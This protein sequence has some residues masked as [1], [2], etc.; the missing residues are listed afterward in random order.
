MN[1]D[2]HIFKLFDNYVSEQTNYT[3][4]Y[5]IFYN[6]K[7]DKNIFIQDLSK[8]LNIETATLLP[9]G[10]SMLKSNFDTLKNIYI[11][12]MLIIITSIFISSLFQTLKNSNK[13]GIY[14]LLGISNA[15][16]IKNN[17]LTENKSALIITMITYILLNLLIPNNNIVFCLLSFAI[18]LI[19]II[20]KLIITIIST[21]IICKKINLINLI[22]KEK[23]TEQ[24]IQFK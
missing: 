3:G 9:S 22:K 18:I 6:D 5:K 10:Y 1:N 16:I 14:R 15:K 19:I 7:N 23:I 12:S 2:Y 20:L 24:I 8:L 21:Y 4:E 11:I 13:I 17:S